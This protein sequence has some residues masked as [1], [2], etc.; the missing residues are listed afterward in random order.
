MDENQRQINLFKEVYEDA[1][2]APLLRWNAKY[3]REEFNGMTPYIC[4]HDICDYNYVVCAIPNDKVTMMLQEL[5]RGKV[6]VEYNSI[7]E[8]VEDGWQLDT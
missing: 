6:I 4:I 8:M 1:M 7:E 3:H 5:N 2:Y